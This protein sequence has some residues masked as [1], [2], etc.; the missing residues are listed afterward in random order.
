MNGL[1][2]YDN[3]VG[4]GF[5]F[6]KALLLEDELKRPRGVSCGSFLVDSS[7]GI[8][9]KGSIRAGWSIVIPPGLVRH[10]AITWKGI[11]RKS[12]SWGSLERGSSIWELECRVDCRLVPDLFVLL[13]QLLAMPNMELTWKH[14]Q[15]WDQSIMTGCDQKTLY[16]ATVWI[17]PGPWSVCAVLPTMTIK[18]VGVGKTIQTDLGPG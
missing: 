2:R 16:F 1:D 17:M 13:C 12:G 6:I 10:S 3:W 4:I 8:Q 14:Q 11:E 18:T 7:P 15:I 9:C 5:C